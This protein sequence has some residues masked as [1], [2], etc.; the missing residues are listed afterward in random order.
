ME[1]RK[2]TCPWHVNATRSFT[3]TLFAEKTIWPVLLDMLQH[4]YFF[5]YTMMMICP[6]HISS[7][8]YNVLHHIFTGRWQLFQHNIPQGTDSGEVYS[9]GSRSCDVTAEQTSSCGATWRPHASY[10][11]SRN[12]CKVCC[13]NCTI[14]AGHLIH[15]WEDLLYAWL[16]NVLI[17]WECHINTYQTGKCIGKISLYNTWFHIHSSIPCRDMMWK[18]EHNF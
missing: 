4:F 7:T 1:N 16:D 12:T 6:R 14:N 15:M 5:S 18:K 11:P 2:P 8:N 17:T 13:S 3:A 9:I 10:N